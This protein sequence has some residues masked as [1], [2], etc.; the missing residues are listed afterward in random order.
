VQVA[1]LQKGANVQHRG[2]SAE[3]TADFSDRSVGNLRADYVLPS[4]GVQI[5]AAR[6]Y[7]PATG[8]SAELVE[9]SDHRLVFLDL[10]WK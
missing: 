2:V 8:E 1:A 5:E 10:R 6:V 3:D 9:C 4:V 7:W